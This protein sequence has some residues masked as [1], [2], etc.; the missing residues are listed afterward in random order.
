M[1]W[2]KSSG[3]EAFT[4][5][6]NGYTAFGTDNANQS[7]GGAYRTDAPGETFSGSVTIQTADGAMENTYNTAGIHFTFVES[8]GGGGSILPLLNAYYG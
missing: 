7:T 8:G 2:R 4:T 6:D 3:T 1:D 5:A